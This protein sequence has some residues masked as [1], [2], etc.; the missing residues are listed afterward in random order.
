MLTPA[1]QRAIDEARAQGGFLEAHLM[2]R[3]FR[4]QW[5]EAK[6]REQ[7]KQL[8]WNR[9]GVDAIDAA[10]GRSYEVLTGTVTNMERHGRRMAD[11]FFRLITF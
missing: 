11:V 8:Q 4:G 9:T 10:T 6:L 1:Q 2:K 3:R 7:F 5:V